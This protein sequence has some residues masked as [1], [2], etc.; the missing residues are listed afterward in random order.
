MK[1]ISQYLTIVLFSLIILSLGIA[2]VIQ[3][4]SKLSYSERRKLASFP[5]FTWTSFFDGTFTQD[6]S[7][8][9]SDQFPARD[10]FRSLASLS[11]LNLFGQTD[12]SGLY[13]ND[14]YI[15]KIDYPLNEEHVKKFAAKTNEVYEEYLKGKIN[16]YYVSVIPS[17]EYYEDSAHL[18]ADSQEIADIFKD[19]VV[20]AEYLDLFSLLD[21]DSYYKTDT[22]WRQEKLLPVVKYLSEKMGFT[23][24]TDYTVNSLDSF[25]GVYYGQLGIKMEPE[26]LSYL[27]ND[28]IEGAKVTNLQKPEV[29]TVY[30]LEAYENLDSYDIY[31]SGASPLI[32]IENQNA[33]SEKELVIFRD[34]YTSSLAPLM[35]EGYK[36]ITLIDLRYMSSD[37]L[38]EYVD[39]TNK[40]VLVIY[41]SLLLNSTAQLK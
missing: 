20:G 30:D 13:L 33:A 29:K 26:L 1:K 4:D 21:K 19:E 37:L 24:S 23:S 32:T 14:G 41:S 28:T 31:L 7:D 39:F 9:I 40:D 5:T 8:Y 2:G 27:T 6:F 17:K 10:S 38:P 18:K 16:N 34:S 15:Y 36:S 11:R 22:H 25:Y 35:I 3:P 12:A